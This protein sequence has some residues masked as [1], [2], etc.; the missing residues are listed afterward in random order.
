[1]FG[2]RNPYLIPVPKATTSTTKGN[3]ETLFNFQAATFR[4]SGCL[5]SIAFRKT[6]SEA[7]LLLTAAQRTPRS[8]S[9]TALINIA[10]VALLLDAALRRTLQ[11]GESNFSN[12]SVS[13]RLLITSP[14]SSIAP[15]TLDKLKIQQIYLR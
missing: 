15:Q 9:S 8:S 5:S 2:N 3:Q 6:L 4:T 13:K 10:S 11:S 7:F 12:S 14:F 1:M